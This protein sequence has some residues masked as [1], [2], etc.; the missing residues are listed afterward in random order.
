[1]YKVL[2]C[3]FGDK[4]SIVVEDSIASREEAEYIV[5][6]ATIKNSKLIYYIEGSDSNANLRES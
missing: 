6:E 2:S 5:A 4:L 3:R 1:M